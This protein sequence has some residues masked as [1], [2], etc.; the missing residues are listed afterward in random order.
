[1][2]SDAPRA[3]RHGSPV[4]KVAE[5]ASVQV[6]FDVVLTAADFGLPR[7][8]SRMRARGKQ[9]IKSV[10]QLAQEADVG[11]PSIA[12]R[13]AHTDFNAAITGRRDARIA[14]SKLPM[15]PTTT[16]KIIPFAA[17]QGVMRN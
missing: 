4:T 11:A 9:K 17:S 15:T 14:G 10:P 3:T 8:A 12:R 1:M 5:I 2:A 13:S 6:H 16:A 7:P